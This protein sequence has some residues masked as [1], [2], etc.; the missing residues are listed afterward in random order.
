MQSFAI[1]LKIIA[2]ERLVN[3]EGSIAPIP[4]QMTCELKKTDR[5]DIGRW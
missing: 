4:G 1:I 2:I 5:F 3:F